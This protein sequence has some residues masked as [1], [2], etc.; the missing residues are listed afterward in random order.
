MIP[1]AWTIE[2]KGRQTIRKVTTIEEMHD[3]LR[4]LDL[5]GVAP[6][7]CGTLEAWNSVHGSYTHN[8]GGDDEW[9]LS[10]TKV[11]GVGA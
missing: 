11:G 7:D 1:Y 6:P 10:W 5:P 3:V 8:L 9:S 4:V 2:V